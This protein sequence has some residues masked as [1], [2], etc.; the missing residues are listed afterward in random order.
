MMLENDG[1]MF[2][3]PTLAMGDSL[4]FDDDFSKE[5]LA[6]SRLFLDVGFTPI[7]KDISYMNMLVSLEKVYSG[8]WISFRMS[9]QRRGFMVVLRQ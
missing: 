2:Y 1:I 3:L 5:Q 8:V 7:G 9:M 4:H 6:Q